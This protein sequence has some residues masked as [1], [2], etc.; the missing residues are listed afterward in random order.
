[1]LN[2]NYMSIYGHIILLFFLL[3]TTLNAQD[4]YST[5]I[6]Y[7]TA[8]QNNLG[9]IISGQLGSHPKDLS[10]VAVEGAYL[11]EQNLFD[12][13][14]DIY[15]KAGF[16]Y[17]NEDLHDNV[18]ETV[19]YIKAYYNFDFL[20]NRVRFGFGEGG[21]Y[22]SSVLEAEH[23]E[24]LLENG[25]TS[26]YLNYLD[27]SLDFDIG[28]LIRYKPLDNTYFGILLKHRSGIFGLINNVA[29]GGSN[30]NSIYLE[31]NF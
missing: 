3:T 10:M 25:N 11:L 13:P 23:D 1:M 7:G 28:K 4:K 12:W 5:R 18:L 2:K 22:V 24:A 16:S 31:K 9:T 8:S 14:I 30:Y 29:G 15:V 26:N 17:F 19:V 21:S 27:I 20:D 6:A